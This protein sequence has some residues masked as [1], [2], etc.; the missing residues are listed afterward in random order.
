LLNL[1]PLEDYFL[2]LV[3]IHK[4]SPHGVL[5]EGV[6]E[7]GKWEPSERQASKGVVIN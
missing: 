3:R 4:P 6:E 2:W 7:D 1:L 5:I